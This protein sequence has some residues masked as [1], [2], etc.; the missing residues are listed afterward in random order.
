MTAPKVSI[1]IPNYNHAQYLS[2]RLNSIFNQNYQNFEVIIL[3]DCSID[4]SKDIIGKYKSNP[5]VSHIIY[6]DTNSGSPFK[7]WAKGLKLAQGDYIWIAESDDWAEPAFLKNMVPILEQDSSVSIVFCNSYNENGSHLIKTQNPFNKTKKI[8]HNE[9][10]KKHL[11]WKCT[12]YNASS[13]LFRRKLA[14]TICNDYQDFSSSGDYLFWIYL[15]ELGNVYYIHVPLNHYRIHNHNKSIEERVSGKAFLE[16]LKIF[17]YKKEKHYSTF[18][19][20]QTTVLNYLHQINAQIHTN[21]HND[22]LYQARTLWRKEI[23]SP[24]LSTLIVKSGEFIWKIF[25]RH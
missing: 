4:N 13:A 8:N 9:M 25:N 1:I 19:N 11:S 22:I 5:K 18:F 23:L 12:I 3:D 15:A 2:Q 14:L 17:H 7:Q 16:D 6:N 24:L 10:L 20:R 21:I